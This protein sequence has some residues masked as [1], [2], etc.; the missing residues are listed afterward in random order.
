MVNVRSISS[1]ILAAAG[2]CLA[3][4]EALADR[5]RHSHSG[6]HGRNHSS[7]SQSTG[8]HHF[9]HRH[10]FHPAPRVVIAPRRYYYYAPAPLFYRP[11]VVAAAPAVIVPPPVYPSLN[12]PYWYFC[13]DS[14]AYYPHVL[15]CPSGWLQVVPTN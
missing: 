2:I 13:P 3:V 11:P 1:V 5:S 7:H 14:R 8:R 6:A 10:H 12:D 15:E 9:S 4:P